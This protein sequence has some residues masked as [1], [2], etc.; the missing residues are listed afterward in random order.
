[1]AKKKTAATNAATKPKKTT[2]KKTTT[3]SKSVV[4]RKAIQQ[5]P[6]KTEE[7]KAAD[8][9]AAAVTDNSAGETEIVAT[10]IKDHYEASLEQIAKYKETHNGEDPGLDLEEVK[11][12]AMAGFT[13][14]LLDG[15]SDAI[16]EEVKMTIDLAERAAADHGGN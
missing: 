13:T 1:M 4:R 12:D 5:V 10:P 3:K 6:E 15:V 16:P 2:T 8:G 14:I 9:L 7:E 11:K